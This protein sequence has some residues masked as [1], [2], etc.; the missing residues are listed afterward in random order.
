M[1]FE[2]IVSG[3]ICLDPLQYAYFFCCPA[4]DNQL[5]QHTLVYNNGKLVNPEILNQ[6][7]SPQI[8]RNFKTTKAERDD[9]ANSQF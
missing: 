2:A 1:N 5:D 7:Q 4:T 3:V 6:S 8:D 9:G